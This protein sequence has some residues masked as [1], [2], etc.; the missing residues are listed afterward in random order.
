M[1]KILSAAALGLAVAITGM[2]A[3]PDKAE[4]A[5]YRNCK[6]AMHRGRNGGAVLGALAGQALG[7]NTKSTLI[8]A[9]VGAVAGQHLLSLAGC[10]SNRGRSCRQKCPPV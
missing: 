6:A 7:G 10:F 9:G 3:M 4:A 1:L 2:P 8:G 5:S